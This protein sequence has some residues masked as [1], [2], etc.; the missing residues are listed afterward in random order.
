MKSRWYELKNKAVALRKRGFSIGKIEKNL[1]IPRSTLSGW[2]KD[3]KLSRA[4]K[5]KILE[6]WKNDLK[7]ARKK[8]VVWHNEQK[9][10]R[11]EE[12][13]KNAKKTLSEI[14][15]KNPLFFEL[16]LAFL[17]LGEGSKKNTETAI[18]SSDPKILKFFLVG[19]K[20]IYKL[21]INKI[22]CELGLRA[23]QD[24]VKIKRYWSRILEL[25][26]VNFKQ[27]NI[28]KRTEG[29]VTYPYYKGVCNL[30]CGNVA[31]QRKLV[32]LA[33]LYCEKIISKN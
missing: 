3:I 10:K 24:P 33:N 29:I 26:L 9:R 30:R 22:R 8:A 23:D 2:L 18:G 5:S 31:I 12:A 19:L 32:N 20:K 25:P 1:G 6:E 28:D 27:V 13:E 17:Y 14:N 7:K 11:L 16:A 21:D 4:Q 15:L